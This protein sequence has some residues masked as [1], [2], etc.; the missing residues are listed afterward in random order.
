ML[1]FIVSKCFTANV[2]CHDL[3]FIRAGYNS[4]LVIYIILFYAVSGML[5]Y[6]SFRAR[7][8]IVD[9]IFLSCFWVSLLNMFVLGSLREAVTLSALC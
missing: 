6:P 9:C 8:D 2:I 7:K 5:K 3:L 1:S 4:E